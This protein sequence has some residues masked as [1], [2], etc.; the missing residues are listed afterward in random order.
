MKHELDW[1]AIKLFLSVARCG[2]LSTA[3]RLT[4]IS[5]ATLGRRMVAL[6][7]QLAAV[8]F[9][10]EKNGYHLTREGEA[11][12]AHAEQLERS[13]QSIEQWRDQRG[14]A[15]RVR[16]SAG[17]WICH[18]LATHINALWTAAD[19]FSVE[20]VSNPQRVDIGRRHADIGIRNTRPEE[21]WL[22][23]RRIGVVAFAPYARAASDAEA[24][25]AKWVGYINEN[26]ALPSAQWLDSRYP[27]KVVMRS[28]NPRCILD[29]V[30][31]GIGRAVLPCF[32]GDTEP[33]LV[34]CGDTIEELRHEQW[35]VLHHEDR[36]TRKV[37]RVSERIAELM[38]KNQGLFAGEG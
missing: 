16:I 13:A 2:G 1:N 36:H 20:L 24:A 8:L 32:V 17:D 19:S 35:L 3:A 14:L 4:R 37:R 11:L 12:L 30:R 31:S 38:A 27:Q 29:L 21:Q 28:N 34:R 18:F 22:A 9:V 23:R 25:Q 10:R 6:E 15:G 26:V 5:P 7:R 33:E